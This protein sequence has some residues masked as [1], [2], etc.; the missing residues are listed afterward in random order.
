MAG[1]IAGDHHPNVLKAQSHLLHCTNA[2]SA[3]GPQL[4]F[5]QGGVKENGMVSLQH[6]QGDGTWFVSRA[7][8]S[9]PKL[10]QL[11]QRLEAC[12][13]LYVL[14]GPKFQSLKFA[15]SEFLVSESGTEKNKAFFIKCKNCMRKILATR[16]IT[17]IR[18]SK[19]LEKE[20]PQVV[21]SRIPRIHGTRTS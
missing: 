21:M 19:G 18:N 13:E 3:D 20:I 14:P 1:D 12:C 4:A 5:G 11:F 6:T 7:F 9:I 10:S 15:C 8:P 17:N 2:Q 16:T